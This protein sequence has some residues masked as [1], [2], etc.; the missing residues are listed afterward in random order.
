ME[1]KSLIMWVLGGFCCK[2]GAWTIYLDT[3]IAGG[4][5][6]CVGTHVGKGVDKTVIFL[7]LFHQSVRNNS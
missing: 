2:K 4:N 6:E 3:G 7:D 1:K 5:T